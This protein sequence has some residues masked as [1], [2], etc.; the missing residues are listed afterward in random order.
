MQRIKLLSIVLKIYFILVIFQR[1]VYKNTQAAQSPVASPKSGTRGSSRYPPP[2]TAPSP[3]SD[4]HSPS[5]VE[6]GYCRDP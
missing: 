1:K 6:S 5:P 2:R 3:Q 4:A